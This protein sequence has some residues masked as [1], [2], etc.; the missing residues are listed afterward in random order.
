M[1]R[2]LQ[3]GRP[4]VTCVNGNTGVA[5]ASS[6][7]S[8]VLAAAFGLRSGEAYPLVSGSEPQGDLEF[9]VGAPAT[10]GYEHALITGSTENGN[11]AALVLRGI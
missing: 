4:K 9:V 5:E 8:S 11:N 6:G 3:K 7:V 1:S 10:G 2:L